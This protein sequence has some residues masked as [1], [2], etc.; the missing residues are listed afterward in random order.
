MVILRRQAM[1]VNRRHL[2][3]ATLAPINSGVWCFRARLKN[4]VDCRMIRNCQ[5]LRI[6]IQSHVV[7]PRLRVSVF[8]SDRPT[9][10]FRPVIRNSIG[11]APIDMFEDFLWGALGVHPYIALETGK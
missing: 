9:G 7:V 5:E 10:V 4:L 11:S 3:A 1:W 2:V 6:F 8:P